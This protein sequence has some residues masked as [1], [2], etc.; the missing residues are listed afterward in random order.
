M[1]FH[2]ILSYSL[3]ISCI[4]YME[5]LVDQISRDLSLSCVSEGILNCNSHMTSNEFG[6]TLI[7]V[8]VQ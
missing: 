3:T 2:F 8:T 5:Y 7:T 1:L 4:V 6:V